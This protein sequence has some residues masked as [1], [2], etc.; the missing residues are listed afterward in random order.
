MS[1]KIGKRIIRLEEI[2]STNT[3]LKKNIDFIKE[4][5]LVIITKMQT[6]GRGRLGR[7]FISLPN[8]NVTFSVNLH[9]NLPVE[10]AQLYSLLAGIVVSRVI[11]KYLDNVKLKWPNDVLVRGKKICGILIET[12]KINELQYPCLILGI[13]L[14]TKGFIKDYPNELKNVVTTLEEELHRKSNRLV[15][16]NF[17]QS[18]ENEK[19]FQELLEELEICIKHFTDKGNPKK[20]NK[21]NLHIKLLLKEWLYRSKAIG[22]K[23]RFSSNSENVQYSN[24]IGRIEGLT[25]E[26]YL[27]IR[28]ESGQLIVHKSGDIIEIN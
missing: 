27:K 14:N 8:K 10:Q 19:I 17:C 9:P 1:R 20:E 13:G 24:K 4:H 2:D 26:G 23:V 28:T 5:G 7:K 3:Y 6:S 12:I 22:L 16:S 18:P 11:G 25:N 15:N 21:N